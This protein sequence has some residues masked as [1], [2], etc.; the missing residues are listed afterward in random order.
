MVQGPDHNQGQKPEDGNDGAGKETAPH[1][2][3]LSLDGH[4]LP[5]L[6]RPL[7]DGSYTLEDESNEVVAA[8]RAEV[9]EAGL[10]LRPPDFTGAMI[11]AA[12]I[13]SPQDVA[14]ALKGNDGDIQRTTVGS[15]AAYRRNFDDI[16]GGSNN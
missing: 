4:A 12:G 14:R 15:T 11:D 13:R 3:G 6:G 9:F 10:L 7:G 2:E 5:D 16:F 8:G 1:G